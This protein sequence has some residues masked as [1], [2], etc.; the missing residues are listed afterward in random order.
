VGLAGED[1][2]SRRTPQVAKLER[3]EFLGI[4]RSG[5]KPSKR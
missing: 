3:E 2:A 4:E 5:R 1:G